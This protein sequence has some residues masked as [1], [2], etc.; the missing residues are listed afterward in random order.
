[1]Y[2]CS[3]N[4]L[5]TSF[6]FIFF[7]SFAKGLSDLGRIIFLKYPMQQWMSESEPSYH[8][9]RFCIRDYILLT[10]AFR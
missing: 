2:L 10:M 9:P 6:Y 3:N 8:T 1:M 5:I 7:L 4:L